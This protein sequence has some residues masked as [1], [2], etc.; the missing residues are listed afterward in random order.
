MKASERRFGRFFLSQKLME[1]VGLEVLAARIYEGM[2]PTRLEYVWDR[3]G[4][5]V[6]AWCA[7]FEPVPDGN[8]IPWYDV[9][10]CRIFVASFYGPEHDDYDWVRYINGVPL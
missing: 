7:A 8:L 9:N 1:Q 3:Y 4:W 6:T 10:L 2:L 5:E